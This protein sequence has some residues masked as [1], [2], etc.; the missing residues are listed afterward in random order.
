M[1]QI[2][3]V[4]AE[5]DAALALDL[6]QS[7]ADEGYRIWQ[8]PPGR[9]P[10]Q[11]SY[12][13]ILEQGMLGSAAIVLVWSEQAS[14]DIGVQQ[15]LHFLQRICR[16]VFPILLDSTALPDLFAPPVLL[17]WQGDVPATRT[18]LCRLPVFPRALSM[19][20]FERFC[21]Q[22]AHEHI[23]QRTQ[24]IAQA[25]VLLQQN[26]HREEVL[27]IL[28]YLARYD[29]I[30]SVQDLA[31]EVL[32]ADTAL[33]QAGASQQG[34]S[35]ILL[36]EEPLIESETS[37]TLAIVSESETWRGG[38][39]QEE[40]EGRI[41]LDP[42]SNL[43]YTLSSLPEE[44][45]SSPGGA[46]WDFYLVD[47]P[48][49]LHKAPGKS[50][51]HEVTF[52]LELET[53]G[54]TAFD[55]FPADITTPVHDPTFYTVSAEMKIEKVANPQEYSRSIRFTSI[56]P[57]I[58]AF[59]EGEQHVYW[60]YEESSQQK[61]VRPGIRHTLII[62]RVPHGTSAI[63][64]VIRYRVVIAKHL[65]GLWRSRE[66]HVPSYPV[67]WTL[68]KAVPS[69]FPKPGLATKTE[70]SL[71]PGN[72]AHT[73]I[74]LLCALA[75]EAEGL[76]EAFREELG[77]TFQRAYHDRLRREYDYTLIRNRE[78]EEL[79]VLVSWLPHMGSLETGMHVKPL[80][81][82][83]R[84]RFAAM[85][86][87]CAGDSEKVRLGDI[88]VAERAFLYDVGKCVR[89]EK[90]QLQLRHDTQTWSPP[91]EVIHFAH[92]F[93]DWQ[94]VVAREPRPV[95]LQQ[96][97]DWLLSA[98]LELHLSQQKE[99]P[100]IDDLALDELERNAPQWRTIVWTL[101]QGSEA[102][103]T[104]ERGLKDP[105]KI[106]RLPYGKEVFPYRDPPQPAVVIAPVGSGNAV[107]SDR[108]FHFIKEPVRGTTAIDMEGAAF[109]RTLSEFPTIHFLFVKGVSDYADEQKDDSYH[110]YAS[111]AS[112]RYLLAFV[113]A[114]VT[115]RRLPA[116]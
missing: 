63:D 34:G 22:A 4:F 100:R 81:E 89:D 46:E 14:Q 99:R 92:G 102:Y 29:L 58:T 68:G 77:V 64:G 41:T 111:K 75:E 79:S 66:G 69:F 11:R 67:R 2:L 52:I 62:L 113:R 61:E 31:Q 6:Q 108:P 39:G 85:T 114:Y 116:S 9:S 94:P 76:K 70:R 101:Q 115:T 72:G 45:V 59:G 19:T 35:Q 38:A 23:R 15:Q 50:S 91:I 51:Y 17:P 97:R 1:T 47:I 83:C 86:G 90:G 36:R 80:L 103:L 84:P 48:F 44:E 112:A 40:I 60:R 10:Q 28:Q 71:H 30:R 110:T 16:V 33:L 57:I 18:A 8:P 65:R 37:I 95:T 25:C 12:P 3:L 98:L 82:E 26:Q 32:R 5:R 109:Y 88:I 43:L 20:A 56:Y 107:R 13:R 55:L 104:A 53:P 106:A 42:Q 21:Q 93:H 49:T 27:A 73:D 78:G 24:A 105:Q 74:C 7:L 87:I 54:S 96:Q